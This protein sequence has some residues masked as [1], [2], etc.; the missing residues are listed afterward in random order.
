MGLAKVASLLLVFLACVFS[1]EYKVLTNSPQA[2]EELQVLVEGG[3]NGTAHVFSPDGREFELTLSNGR[4]GIVADVPGMWEVRFGGAK[5]GIAVQ[6]AQI[7]TANKMSGSVDAAQLGIFAFAVLAVFAF[8]GYAA[9]SKIY[10]P[11][12][13]QVEKWEFSK[14]AA[15]KKVRTVF[16]AGGAGAKNFTLED[17]VG[18]G[19]L[20]RP[21]LLHRERLAPG[22]RVAIEYEFDG[23]LLPANVKFLEGGEWRECSS[24]QEA[25]AEFVQAP[26]ADI[27]A[28]DGAIARKRKLPRVE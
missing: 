2:G 17:G 23:K 15:G 13:V 24:G 8:V 12:S 18:E 3:G 14:T 21:M 11:A 5:I 27:D 7:F 9:W 10:V 16:V 19:Y 6:E 4:G 1:Q 26:K 20:G 22:E 28:P 25:A